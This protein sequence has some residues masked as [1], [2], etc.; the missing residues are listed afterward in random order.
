LAFGNVKGM[1]EAVD[2]YPANF[3]VELARQCID[4]GADMF[5]THG[6]HALAGMEIYKGKPIFYGL[7][8]FIFQFGLQFGAGYD[9]LANFEKKS[10]LENPASHE[11]ILATS[12]F[13][14]G[15]LVEVRLFPA[16]LGGARRPISQ[17]GIP[18]EPEPALAEAILARFAEYSAPF[19]TRIAIENG[20]G[21]VRVDA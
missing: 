16:D 1:K 12:H 3:V 19:G 6:V 5:V 15:R 9:V 20:V 2:H 11:A 7:S 13:D 17:M 21:I 8:N 18:L 4:N 14:K 10:E